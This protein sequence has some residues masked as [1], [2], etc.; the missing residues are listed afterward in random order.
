M[1]PI[2]SLIKWGRGRDSVLRPLALGATAP[3]IG[4]GPNPCTCFI[5]LTSSPPTCVLGEGASQCQRQANKQVK[6]S[7]AINLR[8]TD[9][10]RPL[11]GHKGP[12][13]PYSPVRGLASVGS[14]RAGSCG[15]S[16]FL[17][18]VDFLFFAPAAGTWNSEQ[19]G[20][21]HSWETKEDAA[22][23]LGILLEALESSW[24]S[25]GPAVHAARAVPSLLLSSP[26]STVREEM[27]PRSK[28]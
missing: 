23:S 22:S 13:S 11:P 6:H 12:V 24:G 18:P 2:S 27:W 10:D 26:D 25:V 17:A 21:R 14:V 15:L 9:E 3:A 20:W 28:A 8:Q 4:Y 1:G 5:L 19:T 16:L 7:N